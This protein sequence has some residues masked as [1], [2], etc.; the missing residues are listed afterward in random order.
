VMEVM[1]V[2]H[3]MLHIDRGRLEKLA[4]SGIAIRASFGFQIASSR[5]HRI[6][7]WIVCELERDKLCIVVLDT[8]AAWTSNTRDKKL[9]TCVCPITLLCVGYIRVVVLF[10]S[11]TRGP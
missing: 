10:N 1:V 2:G 11:L 8:G 9:D 6:G 3:E 4:S 5:M 7:S